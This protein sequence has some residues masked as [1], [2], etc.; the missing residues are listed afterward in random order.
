MASPTTSVWF[1]LTKK[2][3]KSVVSVVLDLLWT[4]DVKSRIIPSRRQKTMCSLVWD[5]SCLGVLWGVHVPS[6]KTKNGV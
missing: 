3:L 5:Q 1:F 2:D 6:I 4:S